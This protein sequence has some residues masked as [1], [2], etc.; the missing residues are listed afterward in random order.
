MQAGAASTQTV[1]LATGAVSAVVGVSALRIDAT[2]AAE[3]SGGGVPP[4][5]Y[6]VAITGATPHAAV[7]TPGSPVLLTQGN[8]R[9]PS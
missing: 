4:D 8:V 5:R 7:G 3:P 1:D 6:A 9:V 2:D